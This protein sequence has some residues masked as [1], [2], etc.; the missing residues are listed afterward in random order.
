MSNIY[1]NSHVQKPPCNT[2][3]LN[4]LP[5][6]YYQTTSLIGYLYFPALATNLYLQ[7]LATNLYLPAMAPNFYLLALALNLYLPAL[8][9]NLY[10][11]QICIYGLNLAWVC[12]CQPCLT[13]L[14]LPALAPNLYLPALTPNL[15]LPKFVFTGST[16]PQFAYTNLVSPICIY[17]PWPMICTHIGCL[18]DLPTMMLHTVINSII[19]YRGKYWSCT[20]KTGVFQNNSTA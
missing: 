9:P 11:P 10:L 16:R 15:C 14:Y 17:W 1:I 13:N 2:C 7:A 4:L 18:V 3:S 6:I 20:E 19:V 5:I 12:I 8:T